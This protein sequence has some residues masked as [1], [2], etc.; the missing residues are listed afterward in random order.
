MVRTHHLPHP[1]NMPASWIFCV[2]VVFRLDAGHGGGRDVEPLGELFLAE[3]DR[4]APGSPRSLSSGY[5]AVV[6][7]LPRAVAG[8]ALSMRTA[9]MA[10]AVGKDS[11]LRTRVRAEAPSRSRAS[12]S[13]SC[14]GLA[15]PASRA[16][17]AS[18]AAMAF[19]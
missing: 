5:P 17:S 13:P 3:P 8:M 6:F 1:A 10:A 4:L 7:A 12:C 2:G 14:S 18:R 9:A 15:A 11:A 19:L 16:V